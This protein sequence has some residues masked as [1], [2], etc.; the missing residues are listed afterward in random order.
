MKRLIAVLFTL[1]GFLAGSESKGQMILKLQDALQVA[2][3]SSPQIRQVRLNL[4][5]VK[6]LLNAQE[7]SLKSNFRFTLDPISYANDRSFNEFYNTWN[8]TRNLKSQGSFMVSQPIPWTDGNVGLT[9]RFAWQNS[10]S[11]FRDETVKS[12]SNNLYLSYSQPLFTY[13]RTKL[14]M[15]ELELDYENTQINYNLQML[16]LERSV[17]SSFYSVYQQQMRVEIA[18]EEYLN[19][20]TN[21][22][23]IQNKVEGGLSR[24]E[25]FYQAEL[26]LASSKSSWENAKVTLEDRKDQFKILIGI[27]IDQV[28][29]VLADPVVDSIPVNLPTAI[30]YGL[31]NRLELRQRTIDIQ[32]AQFDLIRTKAMNEFNGNLNL[33]VGLFGDNEKFPKIYSNPND[34]QQIALTFNIPIF[35]WGERKARIS[36]AETSI[37]TQQLNQE[38]E[39]NDIVLNIRQT[40][41]N[42]QN[43]LNQ[44]TIA[45]QSK[46]NAQLTYDINL[47]RYKNGD[48]T[49]MDLN[50]YQNQLSQKKTDLTNAQITYK[51]ELL[52][53]KIQTLY[54]WENKQSI[55]P[56][57]KNK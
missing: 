48:L 52:N 10:Y 42:L 22:I 53:L 34:N 3:E 37:Q 46:R 28:I 25:E 21:Y 16:N 12:F 32:N 50:L 23:I 13:N 39:E 57:A 1:L 9:N 38:N 2:G 20:V 24:L 36:A 27:E 51:L 17:A 31:A 35:D 49:G 33:S 19:Q 26:N 14:A 4:D 18:Y 54:D 44:I 41:R 47:E 45:E 11:E 6:Y 5:R 8:T 15:K 29:D 40:Y 7:A 56:Q 43:L 30:S 55:V